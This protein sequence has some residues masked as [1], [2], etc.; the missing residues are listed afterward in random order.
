M[1]KY[2][3]LPGVVL[4][5]LCAF[6]ALLLIYKKQKLFFSI[7]RKQAV[8]AASAVIV[9]LII[10]F[11]K[12]YPLA[13]YGIVGGG[14]DRDE[15]VNIAESRLFALKSPYQARTYLGNPVSLFPGLLILS[16]P[17]FLLGNGAFQNFFWLFVFFLVSVKYLGNP[18]KGLVL[19]LTALLFSPVILQ[20]IVTGGALLSNSIYIVCFIFLFFDSLKDGQKTSWKNIIYAVLLGLGLSGRL[21]FLFVFPL[22]FSALWQKH[23]FKKA[24]GFSALVLASFAL[25]SLPFYLWDPAGITTAWQAQFGKLV[26][27]DV[28]QPSV[29]F[30]LIS[31]CA[32][33]S[34]AFALR[35]MGGDISALFKNCMY[36]ESFLIVSIVLLDLIRG[37]GP[38]Q[39]GYGLSFL[40]FGALGFFQQ[41]SE[42]P[43][44]SFENKG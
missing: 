35:R 27:Y 20:E 6:L 10:L 15:E 17:F 18:G 41:L 1:Q 40:F 30:I 12:I 3:G 33:V 31:I 29:K 43:S 8:L 9:L 44:G 42:E 28:I 36:L 37:M 34:F 22:V 26:E 5:C 4:Y 13:N 7:G 19:F 2:L 38:I 14:S 39:S 23:G 32:A 11:F 25:I 21:N 16:A 24:A